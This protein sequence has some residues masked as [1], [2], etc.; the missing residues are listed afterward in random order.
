MEVE[1]NAARL[2]VPADRAAQVAAVRGAGRLAHGRDLDDENL[3][4]FKRNHFGAHGEGRTGAAR[5]ER[6]YARGLGPAGLVARPGA[7]HAAAVLH[8][9]QQ[10]AG[11]GVAPVGKTDDGFDEIAIREAACR[12]TLELH[13]RRLAARDECFKAFRGQE[14]GYPV[15]C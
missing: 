15:R 5:D 10:P 13:G 9:D 2:A 11:A 8:S 3:P 4:A 12:F 7:T 1:R 14:R 6:L